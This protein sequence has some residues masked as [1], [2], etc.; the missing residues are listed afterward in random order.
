MD[1]TYLTLNSA[2]VS[3]VLLPTGTT[4]AHNNGSQPAGPPQDFRE[5]PQ[6]TVDCPLKDIFNTSKKE[7][8]QRKTPGHYC[9]TMKIL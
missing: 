7:K 5:S 6:V 4:I 9:I 3:D 2:H 8:K 1:P